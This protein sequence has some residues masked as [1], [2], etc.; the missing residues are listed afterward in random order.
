MIHFC[1]YQILYYD[2]SNNNLLVLTKNIKY[3]TVVLT[4]ADGPANTMGNMYFSVWGG[5]FCAFSLVIGILFPNRGGSQDD[6][7]DHTH[8]GVDDQI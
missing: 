5:T 4:S 6:G 3:N 8:N 1:D 7:I 2:D